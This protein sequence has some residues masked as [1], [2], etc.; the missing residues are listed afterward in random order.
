M[1]TPLHTKRRPAVEMLSVEADA[2]LICR[3]PGTLSP[4]AAGPLNWTDLP[5][6]E[7]PYGPIRASAVAYLGSADRVHGW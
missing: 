1:T 6:I 7:G 5:A 4:A 2:V 3:F